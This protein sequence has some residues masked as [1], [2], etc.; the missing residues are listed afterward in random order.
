MATCRDD[1][2]Y[3]IGVEEQSLEPNLKS[4]RFNTTRGAFNALFTAKPGIHKGVIMLGGYSGGFD[5]PGQ[6]YADLSDRLVHSQIA[7]LR[8]DYRHA[9]DCVECGI[10]TLLALQYLDDDA[11]RDVIIIGWSFGA[12]IA[13][14]V[15]SI[16]KTILG[17]AAVST[18]EVADCC[19]RRL[20][21]KPLLLIHGESDMTSP[22]AWPQRIYSLLDGPHDL[23]LYPEVGH[24]MQNVRDRLTDDL[25]NWI[26][27][28]FQH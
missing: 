2:I 6:A 22:V 5:G 26:L 10:D 18:I 20:H 4:L 8:I 17:V 14:G 21:S 23:I 3:V 15:G 9:G 11:I 28:T 24:D 1:A 16:A 12:A 13:M 19:T 7:S 25:H 27:R